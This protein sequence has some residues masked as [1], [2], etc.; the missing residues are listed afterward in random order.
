M[1]EKQDLIHIHGCPN[2]NSKIFKRFNMEINF[3]KINA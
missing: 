1:F 2:Q 3:I